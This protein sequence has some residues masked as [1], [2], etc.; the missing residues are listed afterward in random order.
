[1]STKLADLEGSEAWESGIS[2]PRVLF[3]CDDGH[4]ISFLYNHIGPASAFGD[5]LTIEVGKTAKIEIYGP[6]VAS[7]HRD[8][9]RAK[10]TH[11]KADGVDIL[12]VKV[13]LG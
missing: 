6:K 12:S 10:C 5:V 13:I 8:F 4:V 11:I 1:M 3:C 9:C 7:L 2:E